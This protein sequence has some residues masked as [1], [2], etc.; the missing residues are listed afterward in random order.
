MRHYILYFS[1]LTINFSLTGCH[2]QQSSVITAGIGVDSVRVHEEVA[3]IQITDSLL[4][5][6]VFQADSIGLSLR[7]LS[8]EGTR[9]AGIDTMSPGYL[10][11]V[12]K[13]AT[14]ASRKSMIMESKSKVA[15][16][17]TTSLHIRDT[18]FVENKVDKQAVYE[19][20]DIRTFLLFFA[21][22]FLVYLVFERR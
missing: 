4:Q 13:N 10:Q 21:L 9:Q 18:T 14:F 6:F 5:E 1:L 15:I 3:I 22:L 20:P 8:S 19:P 16:E 11:I 17:D 2:T 7:P 12:A